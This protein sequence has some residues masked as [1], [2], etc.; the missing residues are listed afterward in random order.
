M[1]A[2][3]EKAVNHKEKSKEKESIMKKSMMKMCPCG[4]EFDIMDMLNVWEEELPFPVRRLH[5]PYGDEVE[6]YEIP[7]EK[8]AEIL[9]KMYPFVG[10]PSLDDRKYDLHHQQM[11]TVRD[12]LVVRRLGRN[13]LVSPYFSESG[14]TVL[15]WLDEP[16]EEIACQKVK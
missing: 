10:V 11:F 13:Y 15:D 6:C 5:N 9:N 4:N 3:K 14:G 8:K 1:N 12:F 2:F 7:V 16:D